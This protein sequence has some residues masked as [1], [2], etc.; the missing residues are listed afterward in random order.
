MNL[1]SGE[2]QK[3]APKIKLSLPQITNCISF[4]FLRKTLEKDKNINFI[5]LRLPRVCLNHIFF[6]IHPLTSPTV[7]SLFPF[8][9]KAISP[10]NHPLHFSS[11][12][13]DIHSYKN[14]SLSIDLFKFTV[15]DIKLSFPFW[16][17]L[18]QR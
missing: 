4:L 11:A 1:W 15:L 6:S 3:K 18:F 12:F 16:N 7:F 5:L 9:D 13:F 2:C 10:S 17:S 8:K 14:I